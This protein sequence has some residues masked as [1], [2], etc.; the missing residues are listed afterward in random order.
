MKNISKIGLLTIALSALAVQ[1]SADNGEIS[2]RSGAF[3]ATGVAKDDEGQNWF[4]V[5]LDYKLDEN[6][7]AAPSSA[8]RYSLSVDYYGK[9]GYHNIPVLLNY[10]GKGKDVYWSGGVGVAFQ[11]TPSDS[12]VELGFQIALGKNFSLGNEPMFAEL[13]YF[14]TSEDQLNGFSLVAGIRF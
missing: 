9:G 2:L 6:F 13:R 7:L 14:G 5:G 8:G 1:A 10:T 12:E 4:T 3:F 11:H